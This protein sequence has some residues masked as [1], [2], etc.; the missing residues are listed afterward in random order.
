MFIQ[1]EK[2]GGGAVGRGV[3]SIDEPRKKNPG[4]ISENSNLQSTDKTEEPKEK[5]QNNGCRPAICRG[6]TIL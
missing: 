1:K 6:I 2:K 5:N 3:S 4:L